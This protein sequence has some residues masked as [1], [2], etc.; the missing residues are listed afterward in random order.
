[1]LALATI[2]MQSYLGCTPQTIGQVGL[3]T[4]GGRYS[5]ATS[6][7]TIISYKDYQ[8]NKAGKNTLF[9]LKVLH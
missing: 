6:A 2:S 4:L 8:S 9:F 7:K 3:A 5:L 1:M